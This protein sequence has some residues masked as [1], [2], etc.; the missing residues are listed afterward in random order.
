MRAILLAMSALLWLFLCVCS[1]SPSPNDR[2]ALLGS[3]HKLMAEIRPALAQLQELEK[4]Y[5]SASGIEEFRS[6]REELHDELN[7]K[8]TRLGNM[9]QEFQALNRGEVYLRSA[10]ML[11]GS[12]GKKE[13]ADASLATFLVY[14][15]E[16]RKVEE[17]V[18][19]AWA[20]E[21]REYAAF[22]ELELRLQMRRQRRMIAAAAAAAVVLLG[23]V[24]WRRRA[25]AVLLLLLLGGAAH[26]AEDELEQRMEKM[27]ILL[28]DL[29]PLVFE[30]EELIKT[31][32][33]VA[34]LDGVSE[35][36][37][38][39]RSRLESKQ[40]ELWDQRKEFVGANQSDFIFG[41]VSSLPSLSK[42]KR[43]K[44]D[45]AIGDFT[46]Y[47]GETTKIRTFCEKAQ[48]LLKQEEQD[49]QALKARLEAE[50]QNRLRRKLALWASLVVAVGLCAWG[51]LGFRKAH[52]EALS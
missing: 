24:A 39:L 33:A 27:K 17:F 46:F 3:M 9:K 52:A 44:T 5:G 21:V 42:G 2:D 14:E 38:D 13:A 4:R 25:A 48:D 35:R 23:I 28:A 12:G 19:A 22:R 11:G 51:L 7:G 1:A 32:P 26:S 30:L 37:K 16:P 18:Q 15:D 31:Y 49:F 43:G 36:R 20:V 29:R 40:D 8:L 6:K 50:E 47:E 45:S 41:T 34:D 10:S